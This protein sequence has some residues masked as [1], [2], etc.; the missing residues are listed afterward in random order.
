MGS[1]KWVVAIPAISCASPGGCRPPRPPAAP[2][3][4]ATTLLTTGC[5]GRVSAPEA[6]EG[7]SGG[8]DPIPPPPV[9]GHERTTAQAQKLILASLT[10]GLRP[11]RHH[12]T[13]AS[14]TSGL[15]GRAS[16]PR[17]PPTGVSGAPEAPVG[18][19]GGQWPHP[20][21]PLA[22]QAPVGWVRRGGRPPGEGREKWPLP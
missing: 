7:K 6:P 17:T 3:G 8:G 2:W 19:P 21:R 9:G 20:V 11:P 22:P 12:P 1:N 5:R 4:G 18:C 15:T 14:G 13:G 16:A 10:G